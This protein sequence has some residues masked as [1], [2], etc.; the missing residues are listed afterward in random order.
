M[1]TFLMGTP[2]LASVSTSS[3]QSH[4]MK[5]FCFGEALPMM[6]MVFCSEKKRVATPAGAAIFMRF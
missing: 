5:I 6:S 1:L 4:T 2:P 3:G